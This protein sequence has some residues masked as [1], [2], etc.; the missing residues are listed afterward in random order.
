MLAPQRYI[1]WL[2]QV[3]FTFLQL[4]PAF[5]PFSRSVCM[6]FRFVSLK[7]RL[8]PSWDKTYDGYRILWLI[9]HRVLVLRVARL[10]ILSEI[11]C[12]SPILENETALCMLRTCARDDFVPGNR[13]IAAIIH[14]LGTRWRWRFWG[15]I[16]F[17][18]DIGICG[19][20][21]T[22]ADLSGVVSGTWQSVA[23]R[24]N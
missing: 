17:T 22:T 1:R 14:N 8:V 19:C 23:T 7:S 21:E 16:F 13:G 9:K 2:Y 6:T 10:A 15:E 24:E 12:M 11:A 5:T 3:G 18:V 20:H 4:S